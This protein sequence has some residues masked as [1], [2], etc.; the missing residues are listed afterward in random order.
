MRRVLLALA[1]LPLAP[2]ALFAQAKPAAAPQ[3]KVPPSA[4]AASGLPQHDDYI[5][6]ELLAPETNSFKITEDLM[7]A[8]PGARTYSDEVPAAGGANKIVVTDLATGAPLPFAVAGAADARAI[9]VTLARPVPANGLAR[10]RIEKT[11]VSSRTYRR[12]GKDIVFTRTM[13]EK[14]ASVVLPA[15][16]VLVGCDVPS[17]VLSKND[18]RIEVSFMHQGQGETAVTVRGRAGA[19][20]G[21]AAWPKPLTG[22]R[23]WE[24]PAAQGPT[25]SQRLAERATQD[26]DIVYF[27]KDPSTNAFSLYH[28]YTETRAGMDKYVNVVRKGSTV[29]DTSAYIL[30]TGE[31][32]RNDTLRGGFITSANIDIGEP[33]TPDS[34]AV[35]VHFPPVQAGHSVRLRISE[36]YTAPE[37]YRLDGDDLVFDRSFG[38]ARNAVVLPEGWYL[39]WSSI[40]A[41]ISE[42]PDHLVRLDF[43]NGRPDDIS[44][45]IKGRKMK[46]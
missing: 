13:P 31:V 17:Q 28:D 33:V 35:V 8:T 21:Q 3:A 27:L 5:Q 22:N 45:L 29:S 4:A 2:L 23:S 24:K 6:F 16:Y 37:S 18:G 25:E 36:T 44:V 42:T 38:R 43:V 7:I 46:N 39:T 40:P 15:G 9:K 34:E 11:Y 12:E 14:R 32:L 20:A 41:V 30:D 1:I 26:R 10:I 19:P